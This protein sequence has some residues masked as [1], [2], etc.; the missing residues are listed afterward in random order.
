MRDDY[1]KQALLVLPNVNI[2]VN[3]VSWRVK[4]LRK[5]NDSTI[6]SLERLELEDI[7]LREIIEGKLT[8]ELYDEKQEEVDVLEDVLS[9][10]ASNSS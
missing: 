9:L 1:L 4:Q 10:L 7:V 6:D 2:L 5:K 8:Y 3:L